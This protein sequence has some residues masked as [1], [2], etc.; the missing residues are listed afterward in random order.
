MSRFKLKSRDY[1]V[2][3][4][5]KRLF[6][7]RLFSAIAHEY[8]RM[9]RVLSFGLDARWKRHL[10][11]QLPEMHRPT[12]LDLACGNG[13]FILLLLA[14]Y[15]EAQIKGLDIAE[16]MLDLAQERIP[17]GSDVSFSK[18]DIMETG[19]RDASFDIVTIGY[20]LRNAPELGAVMAESARLLKPGGILGTLDF[21]KWNNRLSAQFELALLRLWCGLWGVLRSG[22]ADTYAYISHSLARF[23]SRN[24]LHDIFTENGLHISHSFPHLGGITETIIAIKEERE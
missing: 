17:A 4:D 23:P 19:F 2:S 20:G 12:C 7:E 13:D 6:N 10:V 24:K 3:A 9:T 14:K 8:G 21:S 16:P 11:R 1:L 5:S 22:N 18:G 15:P